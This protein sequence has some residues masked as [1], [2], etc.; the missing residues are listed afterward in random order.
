MSYSIIVSDSFAREL[1]YLSKKY[2]SIKA[3]LAA[4]GRKLLLDPMQGI[5]LGNECYK[6]R[7]A[8]ASKG[9]GRSGGARVITHL[10]IAKE[11]IYLLS[12]Y[13]K[14]EAENIPESE[15]KR[16]LDSL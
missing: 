1:K 15:I 14:S 7:L 4:L 10:K 8:I 3:D 13:D 2:P 6:I 11:H 12:I 9:K 5:A 16:R